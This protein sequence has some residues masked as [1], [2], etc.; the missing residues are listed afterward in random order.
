MGSIVIRQ[1]FEYSATAYRRTGPNN[2]TVIPIPTGMEARMT[3]TPK[4]GDVVTPW[5]LTSNPPGGLTIDYP[6]GE[7][8]IYM[9]ATFTATLPVGLALCWVLDIYDPLNPD[10]VVFLGTADAS[11]SAC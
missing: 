11:V 8:A 5:T 9:G 4:Y 2:T 6:D 1:G 7:I 3:F 10:A